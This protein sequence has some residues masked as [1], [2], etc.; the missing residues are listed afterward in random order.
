MPDALALLAR[1]ARAAASFARATLRAVSWRVLIGAEAF[2]VSLSVL[3][4]L[5]D[6]GRGAHPQLLLA[7]MSR[8]MLAAPFMILAAF[9]GNEAVLRGWPVRRAF[10]V[11]LPCATAAT[12]LCLIPLLG[13]SGWSGSMGLRPSDPRAL[14]AFGVRACV[15][16]GLY[17]GLGMLVYLNR[18]SAARMLAGVR[19]AE[20]A[21]MRLEQR[22]IDSR[23]AAAEAQM[24]PRLVLERLAH[25]RGLYDAR[26]PGAEQQLESL[27]EDLRGK[28]GQQLAAAGVPGLNG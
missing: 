27:I 4:W 13:W 8:E 6:R 19:V 20:L 12:V 11:A 23:L 16:V 3:E 14:V 28:T 5:V 15:G 25:I 22:L 26:Q 24:D 2:A 17:W 1:H 21:R 18:Q 7:M 10:A 9:A